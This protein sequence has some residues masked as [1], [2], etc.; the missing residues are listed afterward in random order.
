M[1]I[2]LND[3]S[4][5]ARKK[6]LAELGKAPSRSKYG[7]VKD[8]RGSIEFDSRKE[9]ARFDELLLRLRAGQVRDLRLQV[10][11][12]LKESYVTPD[13]ERI[14]AIRYIADFAYWA[15]MGDRWVYVVEDV[16]SKA[17]LQVLYY[18]QT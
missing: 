6:V 11:F 5:E 13:G 10:Q 8:N 17:K 9:A 14:R 3:L 7:A 15:N 2:D 12:T 4:L 18:L 1:A 16:K